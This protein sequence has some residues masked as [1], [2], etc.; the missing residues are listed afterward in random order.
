MRCSP[1]LPNIQQSGGSGSKKL[2]HV[3][4]SFLSVTFWLLRCLRTFFYF[5]C[6]SSLIENLTHLG[7]Y[8]L[9]LSTILVETNATEFGGRTLPSY[10]L[11]FTIKGQK[12]YDQASRMFWRQTHS[13]HYS[14]QREKP[15]VSSQRPS[16]PPFV[17]ESHS[18][19]LC[20]YEMLTTTRRHLLQISNL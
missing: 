5:V 12:N 11:N 8:T 9:S 7:K 20:W 13:V 1:L 16:A 4:N 14:S 2:V 19:F 17:S 3:L 18:A 6:I 10:K 15:K